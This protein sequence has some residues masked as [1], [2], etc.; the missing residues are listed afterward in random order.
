MT[1]NNGVSY[2]QVP[3][4]NLSHFST[5]PDS[6]ATLAKLSGLKPAP[7]EKC[8]VLELGCAGGGNLIPM[9][10]G[11]PGSQFV[12]IDL[13]AK[14]ISEGQEKIKTLGLKNVVLEK[15][16]IL[17]ITADL[18]QFDYI[19]A[20]GVFS[21]VPAPVQEGLLEVCCHHLSE[22]GVAFISYNTFPGWYMIN[23]ARDIMR[24]HTRQVADPEERVAQAKSVLHLFAD[25]HK[26]EADGYY[27]FLKL[28]DN[29]LEGSL[30]DKSPKND[31]ALLHDELEDV[32][33]P[34]YFY[35]FMDRAERHGL[36]Y[37]ADFRRMTTDDIKPEV[38]EVLRKNASGL[39]EL[40]QS[41]DF[42]LDRTFRQT[43]LCHKES[44]LKRKVALKDIENYYLASQG[45]L[46]SEDG[47]IHSISLAKFRVTSGAELTTNHPLT[48]AAMLCL[49]DVWPQYLS[50]QDLVT[51][52]R[53]RLGLDGQASVS[54]QNNDEMEIQVLATNLFK[55]FGYSSTLLELHT[56]HPGLVAKPPEKPFASQVARLQ[57]QFPGDSITNL[58]HERVT[59]EE[60]DRFILPYLDGEHDRQSLISILMDG[61]I[62]DGKL[63]L[64]KEG[65]LVDI[66]DQSSALMSELES[67][68]KWL[69]Y[70]SLFADPGRLGEEVDGRRKSH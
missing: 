43:L 29:Y 8:R 24:F 11:L 64:E 26:N 66:N 33:Q 5:H 59:L 46:V 9:A 2:D 36:Q 68:L 35:E 17:D 65:K 56:Y 19:I 39:I 16:D 38:L 42:L 63:R 15:I 25:A 14:Q 6:L 48:K 61:P 67:R 12:G 10:Y 1:F 50:F 20:H 37:L 55:A 58:R 62:A 70:A 54:S 7:V 57:I 49:A 18:G 69:A 4:P 45:K 28:Y 32:N 47:D 27:G 13:S 60:F 30:E 3:Y 31:S 53:Q 21:W 41:L 22:N 44:T 34:L 40:E 51:A 23:I 52:A